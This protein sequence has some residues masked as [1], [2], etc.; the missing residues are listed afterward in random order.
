M[1]F[2]EARFLVF[3]V[4]VFGIYWVLRANRTRKLWLLAT[5]YVFY[6][7]WDWRFL[8]LIAGSTAVDWLVGAA[9]E[10]AERPVA[11]RALLATSLVCNLGLLGFFKYFD[12]F[13]QSGAGLLQWLGL[14]VHPRTL[15]L[16][17]PV[18]I[19]FYTFQTLSYTIDIYRR[20]LKPVDGFLDFALF[21]GFFP[22]LVAGP[23]VRA[24]Q[25]LPQLKEKKRFLDVGFRASL[26][27]FLFG[28][29]KKAVVSDN[30]APVIEPVF[31]A[32]ASFDALSNWVTLFLWHVQIYCD[33]SGY[34]DM[35]IATAGLLGYRMPLNFDFPYF[36]HNIG[37][38]WQRWHITLSTWF[39]DYLYVSLGGSRG[40]LWGGIL[41]GCVTMMLCGLWHGA[42]WQYVGFGVLM[43]AAIILSRAW[44]ELVPEGSGP[45]R[46]VHAL[47]PL[48]MMWFLFLNWIVFRAVSWDTA[49]E[50]L[51][52]FF[53]LDFGGMRSIDPRWFG[54]FVAFAVVHTAFWLGWHRRLARLPDTVWAAAYGV[55]SALVLAFMAVDY[56]PF[57][58]FQF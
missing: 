29:V 5:S 4:L 31:A 32:P 10:R 9:L 41:T 48:I 20:K 1:I 55:G 6:G 47:G 27:L 37:Q 17:L 18:G 25:F 54:V 46:I 58:Y 35:A 21:V 57:I 12:F 38:F 33:F 44:G 16:I 19:S 40:T 22:Q 13:V 3:F 30:I 39:R 15:D 51:A 2:T 26:T 56:Q 14:E 42:G 50:M 8:A 36:C 45:R 7:A 53:F 11:R 49:Q 24:S 23:I 52:V 28:F 43:S 34:S